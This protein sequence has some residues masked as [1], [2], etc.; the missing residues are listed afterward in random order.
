[1]P[2][3]SAIL[4]IK[5]V[6]KGLLIPRVALSGS[7]DV[8][9]ISNPINSLLI[10]NTDSVA[11]VT[12]GFYFWKDNCWE[13]LAIL[14]EQWVN[15]GDKIYYNIG[16][17]GIGTSDPNASFEIVNSQDE[18]TLRIIA[19]NDTTF[20]DGMYLDQRGLGL[21]VN[22]EMNND[23]SDATGV[24]IYHKGRGIG[25][26]ITIDNDSSYATG[27]NMNINSMGNGLN[28]SHY[29]L[30]NGI[31]TFM[32]QDTS[33]ATGLDISH[34]GLGTG[35]NISILNKNSFAPAINIFSENKGTGLFVTMQ[36]DTTFANGVFM[37]M[38]SKGS[39]IQIDHYGTGSAGNMFLVNETSTAHVLNIGQQGLGKGID[40]GMT[41]DTS[42]ES[43]LNVYSAGKGA[44]MFVT[45]Q[46]D[47]SFAT[48]IGMNMYSMGNG[49]LVDQYG[50][51]GGATV[52]I[53]PDSSSA[54]GFEI[55]NNGSGRGIHVSQSHGLASNP[56]IYVTSDH[57]G[58][59]ME[60]RHTSELG[61]AAKFIVAQG[62]IP[63]TSSASGV[64]IETNA[65]GGNGLDLTHTGFGKGINVMMN[66]S[67]SI[68][69]GLNIS[70]AGIG[71]GIDILMNNNL[72]Y[73]SGLF[74]NTMNNGNSIQVI[75][76]DPFG[77]PLIDN[78]TTAF[79][80][81]GIKILKDGN[82]A[83]LKVDNLGPSSGIDI[84]MQ[85]ISSTSP[86]INLT[87]LG[88]GSGI[89][90]AMHN[91]STAKGIEVHHSGNFGSGGYFSIVDDS[92]LVDALY[93]DARG[94]GAG[95]NVEHT[96]VGNGIRV[97]HE[98]GG[99]NSYAAYF[100]K[101][102]TV[103]SS[104]P[105]TPVVY[106]NNRTNA[107][108]LKVMQVYGGVAGDFINGDVKVT[109]G[110]FIDDGTPLNVPDYVFDETY[111]IESIEAH[112]KYMWREK[113][114]PAVSS[115]KV[116][117]AGS[118]NMAERREQILE[119][120]EKAHVYIEQLNNRLKSLEKEN[121]SLKD[122]QQFILQELSTMRTLLDEIQKGE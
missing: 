116:I 46:N 121:R 25:A 61:A 32:G 59:G 74:V 15:N 3:P 98:G 110:S 55:N 85:K 52:N 53:L 76:S 50:L 26:F 29:G 72:S 9:T 48:G 117:N 41:N 24:N 4:D 73:G 27:M 19:L 77:T 80:G 58:S 8:S 11:D 64:M 20:A 10:Y 114:L 91:F 109:G 88:T 87:N 63:D 30:G 101:L 69:T 119:E 107:S 71:S 94:Y 105:I 2:D 81:S 22:I 102:D 112:A 16:N 68:E 115:A 103:T 36:N 45:M 57:L 5:S 43:G 13:R 90:I 89:K 35:A 28:L 84:S 122:N 62:G 93:T 60:V 54:T 100:E 92:S 118:Y 66:E 82:G 12:C 1:M 34:N 120:L 56:G 44:G 99:L 86:G 33:H 14:G 17:V 21:G 106:I 70:Q 39:G 37:N 38:Y 96:G 108:G 18:N 51:G 47:S 7:K 78:D 104:G 40:I 79:G 111:N 113:H 75:H 67:N 23:T 83:G 31:N 65:I 95:L 42:F 97:F 49:I 6:N